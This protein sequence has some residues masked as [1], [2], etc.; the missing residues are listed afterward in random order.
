L[1]A[2]ALGLTDGGHPD[3]YARVQPHEGDAN[4]ASVRVALPLSLAL[5]PGNANGLCEPADALAARCPERS[6]VGDVEART[7]ILRERLV[8]K[9]YFVRGE[10]RDPR[11]GRIIRT[12][13]GL[14]VRLISVENPLL[15]VDLTARSAVVG[16]RLVT[17]FGSVPDVPVSDF[18]LHVYGGRHGILVVS[19]VNMCASRQV[20]QADFIGQNGKVFQPN[21]AI[22]TACPFGV[23]KTSRTGSMLNVTV[24]GLGAGKLSVG[25]PGLGRASRTLSASDSTVTVQV[26]IGRAARAR[27]AAGRNV[28]VRVRVAFRPKGHKVRRAAKRVV[29]HAPRR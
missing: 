25:G 9:V 18:R 1:S 26:P 8:G 17:T 24:S 22:N 23:S 21:V 12:L 4:I 6:V 13:P 5:D 11:T 20:A 10:R 7:P 29:I 19:G 16:N 15:E 3:L 14:L 27:L 2:K 28:A